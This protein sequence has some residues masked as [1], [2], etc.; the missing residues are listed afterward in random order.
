MFQTVAGFI[1][2]QTVA[3]LINVSNCSQQLMFQTV[4]SLIGVS[5]CSQSDSYSDCSLSN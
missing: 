5:D 3:S 2:D 1:N 4:A